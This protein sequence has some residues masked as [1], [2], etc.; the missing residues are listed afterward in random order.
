MT[1][2][3]LYGAAGCPYTSDLRE[4]LAWEGRAFVEYD[5]E[6]DADARDRLRTLTGESR[7]PALVEQGRVVAIGWGGRSCLV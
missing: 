3:E 2:L 1:A 6:A 4:Q 5:V 7:V